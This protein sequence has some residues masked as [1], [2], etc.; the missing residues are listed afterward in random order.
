LVYDRNS[1]IG[2][3]LRAPLS[4]KTGQPL[5]PEQRRIEINERKPI[6]QRIIALAGIKA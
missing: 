4:P 6:A 1:A 5:D 3:P 2:T